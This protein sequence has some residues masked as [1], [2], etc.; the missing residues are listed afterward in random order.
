MKGNV[1]KWRDA[2]WGIYINENFAV[3]YLY[4]EN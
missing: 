2:G 4:R 3:N 1:T